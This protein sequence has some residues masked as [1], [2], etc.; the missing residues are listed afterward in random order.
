MCLLP[1]KVRLGIVTALE[2]NTDLGKPNLPS[3]LLLALATVIA[4]GT[5]V[6]CSGDDDAP[7]ASPTAAATETATSTESPDAGAALTANPKGCVDDYSAST[8]YFPDKVEARHALEWSVS[9]EGNYKVI[10]L[11]SNAPGTTERTQEKY[12]LV[13][14]GT[15]APEL[16]GDLDGA[17]L[18]E[19]PIETMVEAG[20]GL[21]G[22]IEALGVADS[23]VGTRYEPSGVEYLP[24]V[25]AR[26]AAGEVSS[27]GNYGSGPEAMLDLEP[28]LV[29]TYESAESFELYR[30]VDLSVAYYSPWDE[31]PLGAAEQVKWL[32]LFF[33]LEREANEIY[34]GI[35]TRYTELSTR[36]KAASDQ[37]TVLI[38]EISPDGT[39]GSGQFNPVRGHSR[40]VEDAGGIDI[41]KEFILSDRSYTQIPIEQALDIGADADFWYHQVYVPQEETAADFVATDSRNANFAALEAGNAFHRYGRGEDFHATGAVRPDEVLAD[42]VSIIH[43]ELLPDH[44]LVHLKRIEAE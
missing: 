21:Y 27:I 26:F 4:L 20:G 18:F 37:P 11:D 3:H 43:P 31:P 41:M 22:A 33:N 36:A 40:L 39:F 10:T 44:E 14:C 6:A 29:S 17:Y 9:Y 25:E 30:S 2:R 35:E 13:Q 16:T 1:T 7:T 23:L 5:A 24:N 32:S 42:L 38:G 28:D 19:I 12:V 8:D 15:P 34:G